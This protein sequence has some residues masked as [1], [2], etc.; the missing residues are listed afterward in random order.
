MDKIKTSKKRKKSEMKSLK[1]HV[2][3]TSKEL[4]NSKL[5]AETLL[6]CIRNGDTASFR[7]VLTAHLMTVTF[8]NFCD[9]SI[10]G[11]LSSLPNANDL[12]PVRKAWFKE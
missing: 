9:Y 10:F 2:A 11:R 8:N 4:K 5:V 3:F 7:E 6:D 12:K 1:A